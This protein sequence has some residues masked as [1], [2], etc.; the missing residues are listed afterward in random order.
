[1]A[2][3]PFF[4]DGLQRGSVV[5]FQAATQAEFFKCLVIAA[6]GANALLFGLFAELRA[7][8]RAENAVAQVAHLINQHKPTFFA[9]NRRNG[10]GTRCLAHLRGCLRF[11]R[12][13]FC[14]AFFYWGFFYWGFLHR[15]FFYRSFFCGISNM[16]VRK[17]ALNLLYSTITDR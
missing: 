8:T 16:A 12:S 2:A 9:S 3:S 7:A 14:L 4:L 10:R 11:R 13:F 15:N 17:L 1:M 5:L 6:A